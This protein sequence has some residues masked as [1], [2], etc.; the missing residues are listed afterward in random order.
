MSKLELTGHRGRMEWKPFTKE[1]REK[2]LKGSGK[3]G[4]KCGFSFS[5]ICKFLL[6]LMRPICCF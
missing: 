6:R 4:V 3:V 5:S 1:D 2:D